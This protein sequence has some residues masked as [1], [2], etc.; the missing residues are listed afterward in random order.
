VVNLEEGMPTV[1]E[2]LL[3]LDRAIVDARRDAIAFL[4]LIHG[5]GSKGVGGRIREEVWKALERFQRNGMVRAFIRGEDFRISNETTW[6]LIKSAPE[7]KLDRDLGKN[8]R[9]ICVVLF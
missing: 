6:E 3:R 8:N 9:G 5:Y 4:K 2:A 7:I 1:N